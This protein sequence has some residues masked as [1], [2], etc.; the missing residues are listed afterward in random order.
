M[1][2]SNIFAPGGCTLV[3]WEVSGATSV[4]LNLTNPVEN[5]GQQLVCINHPDEPSLQIGFADK[6][7][8]VYPLSVNFV[9]FDPLFWLLI[10]ITIGAFLGAAGLGQQEWV[11]VLISRLRH[12]KWAMIGIRGFMLL[13]I[14]GLIGWFL[15]FYGAQIITTTAREAQINFT[16]QRAWIFSAADCVHLSWKLDHIQA[17]YINEEGQG[18]EGEID[19]CFNTA[20]T[21][22][23]PQINLRVLL[24]DGSTHEYEIPIRMVVNLANLYNVF[25]GSVIV[26]I[27]IA[28]VWQIYTNRSSILGQNEK[29][30]SGEIRPLTSLR[31]IAALL[32]FLHHFGG[33]LYGTAATS[34]GLALIVEGHFGVNIF[35]V[36]SGFLITY[37]YFSDPDDKPLNLFQYIVKRIARIYPLY[38]F[39]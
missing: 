35:F 25:L 22:N 2:R 19:R 28:F 9:V 8:R 32:V 15:I 34:I 31:F 10:L 4:S 21:A 38:Y 29:L 37:R 36:L 23:P 20:T 3:S 13:I 27:L 11:N 18:G 1:E 14:A 39:C 24:A 17:M 6:T 16:V 12:S 30:P 7:S 33:F 26:A 5:S